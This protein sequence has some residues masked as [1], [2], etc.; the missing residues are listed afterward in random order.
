[1]AY[2]PYNQMVMRVIRGILDLRYVE[3]IREEEGGTYGVSIGTSLS[4]WPVEKAT[5]QISFDCD[6]ERAADLKEKV[7]A[8]LE[9]LASEGPSVGDLSKTT[10][11]ILKGRQESKEHNA[12]YLSTLFSYYLY[13]INFDDPANYEDIVK[14]LTPK[15]VKNVMKTFYDDPNI[16]DVVF[17]PKEAAAVE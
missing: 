16:V 11:N 13:G 9:I 3:S 14:G 2:N 7:F 10:E 4:K 15:D 17:V 8:E 1:M 12:Y 5:M 6:P